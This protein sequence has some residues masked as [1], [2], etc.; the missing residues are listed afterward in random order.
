MTEECTLC[1]RQC[2]A[3]RRAGDPG[4]C[5]IAD[6]A[7]VSSAAPHFGEEPPLVGTH[8]SGTIFFCSCNLRC[9]FCQNHS[10]SWSK[11]GS[12]L[13]PAQL[14]TVMI[15]LQEAGC[16]NINVVTPTHVTPQI[17]AALAIAAGRGLRIPLV[18]NCGGFE[19]LSTL[20]LLED[21]VDI[22][23]PDIKYSDDDTARTCS[24]VEHYWHT[25]R[26]A[27]AEMHRQVGNLQLTDEGIA[28][29]GVLIR[30]LVLPGGLAGSEQVLEFIRR[31]ISVDAYVNI[32]DQYRPAHRAFEHPI[33]RRPV[34][35]PEVDAVRRHAQ[36]LG[37]H[38]GFSAGI[39]REIS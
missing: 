7:Y 16:H 29:R 12:P 28:S 24:G 39:H 6:V 27:L 31:E 23:M 30:H 32:M 14:A 34:S 37:L 8:G 5:T 21:I 38:R 1:P 10:I 15:R 36:S 35:H 18:Y 2:G 17:V 3:H 25:A 13:R 20:R 4:L 22:Y 19:S 11:H 26:E 9:I 33:L